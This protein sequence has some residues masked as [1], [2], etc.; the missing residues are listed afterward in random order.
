MYLI[1]IKFCPFVHLLI[2]VVDFLLATKMDECASNMV[3]ILK[4]LAW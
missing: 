3:K 4:V 2:C 1:R